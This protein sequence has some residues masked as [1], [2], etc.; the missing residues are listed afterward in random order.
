MSQGGGGRTRSLNNGGRAGS[1]LRPLVAP[2]AAAI[3]GGVIGRG[4]TSSQVTGRVVGRGNGFSAAD[5]RGKI[6]GKQRVSSTAASSEDVDENEG[7]EDDDNK[8]AF[9]EVYFCLVYCTVQW[10][11]M[12]LLLYF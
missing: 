8:N 5:S 6:A 1:H 2:A 12:L 9:G 3:E 7:F 4:R 10:Y 11:T